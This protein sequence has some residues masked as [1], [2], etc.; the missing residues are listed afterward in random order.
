MYRWVRR[1]TNAFATG[2]TRK[3]FDRSRLRLVPEN[4]YTARNIDVRATRILAL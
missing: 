1:Y 2:Y 3:R 4:V